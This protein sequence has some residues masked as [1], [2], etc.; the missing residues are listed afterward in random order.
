MTDSRYWF[1]ATALSNGEVIVTG[2]PGTF[3]TF[4]LTGNYQFPSAT[5]LKIGLGARP[6]NPRSPTQTG[7]L[8]CSLS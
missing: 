4:T 2:D 7:R 1:T 5:E 3:G 6:E 8:L